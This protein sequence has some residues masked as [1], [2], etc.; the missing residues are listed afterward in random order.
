MDLTA[1]E[2]EDFLVDI[3]KVQR[4]WDNQ[5]AEPG[6][7]ERFE[8]F[9]NNE[10]TIDSY[11]CTIEAIRAKRGKLKFKWYIDEFSEYHCK[12]HINT[13]ED[14]KV[15]SFEFHHPDPTLPDV[16][17]YVKFDLNGRAKSISWTK[18]YKVIFE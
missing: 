11:G 16:D 12:W 10:Y 6:V 5:R 7:E 17:Y 18:H 14:Y 9:D 4:S 3:E 15:L 13:D 2:W 1:A 8:Y